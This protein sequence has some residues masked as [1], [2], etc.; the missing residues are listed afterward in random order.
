MLRVVMVEEEMLFHEA[1]QRTGIPYETLRGVI[2]GKVPVT[3]EL[4]VHL[5]KLA[6]TS[7][8]MW[9]KLQAESGG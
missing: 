4:A 2:E 9:L 6:G 5:S 1:I 8:E 7:P 3:P